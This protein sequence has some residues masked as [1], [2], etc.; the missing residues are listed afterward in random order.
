M[1]KLETSKGKN[2]K[3]NV[4]FPLSTIYITQGENGTYSHMG[5]LAIDFQ[6]YNESRV[7]KQEYYSP[8]TLKMIK[9]IDSN[10]HGFIYESIDKVNYINGECDYVTILVA[11]DDN[12]P[13]NIGDVINQGELLGHTGTFG[14]VTGDHLHIEIAQGKYE[15][16][17]TNDKGVY[18][19]K[20]QISLYN[21][22]GINNTTIKHNLE[23]IWSEFSEIKKNEKN[24]KYNW[25]LYSRNTRS[26][27]L[28]NL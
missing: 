26:R 15:G 5:S 16:M 14:N 22:M 6:G 1:K 24:S 9:I 17:F 28:K 20:N 19:L 27:F 25:I 8:C 11:H 4:L 23:Y 10:S 2:G 7:Y 18:C 3:E 13:Y 21:V 12:Q